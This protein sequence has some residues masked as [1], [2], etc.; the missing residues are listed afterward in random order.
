LTGSW[1]EGL[2]LDEGWSDVNCFRYVHSLYDEL[3]EQATAFSRM[4]CG[5]AQAELQAIEAEWKLA[6]DQPE[7]DYVLLAELEERK[8]VVEAELESFAANQADV[9]QWDSRRGTLSAV[10]TQLAEFIVSQKGR[11]RLDSKLLKQVAELR[12]K[13][14]ELSLHTTPSAPSTGSCTVY[15]CRATRITVRF[16]L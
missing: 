8:E 10:A 7:C 12:N 1:A 5:A 3:L 14:K 4:D 11:G 13:L 9:E 15:Y 6:R 2:R 16:I